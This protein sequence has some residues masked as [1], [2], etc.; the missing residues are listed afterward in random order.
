MALSRLTITFL[1]LIAMAPLERHTE[2]IIGSISGVRPTATAIAKKNALFQSCLVKPLIKKTRGTMTAMSWIIS[3]VK[4]LRPRS[5]LVGGA[6]S[7]IEPAMVP[8]YVL[9]P[10]TT[11]TAVA[12]QISTLVPMK[13]M[14][15]RSIGELVAWGS[16][17][18]N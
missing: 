16:G 14:F 2:T 6:S 17:S 5:K 7:V 9:T 8:R 12:V 10:V 18:W 1:R 11:T 13:Q 15:F 4:R 3:H